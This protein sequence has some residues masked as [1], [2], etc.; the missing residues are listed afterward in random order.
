MQDAP[1]KQPE[2]AERK[3]ET[4]PADPNAA[5]KEQVKEK[6]GDDFEVNEKM[7][8]ETLSDP[9]K[10]K[11]ILDA[12]EQRGDMHIREMKD[13]AFKG[14]GKEKMDEMRTMH[15]AMEKW[16]PSTLVE[17][18]LDAVKEDTDFMK[19]I[20]ETYTG[21]VY[22]NQH[23]V[24]ERAIQRINLVNDDFF[25]K[26]YNNYR[27]DSVGEEAVKKIKDQKNLIAVVDDTN[28]RGISSGGRNDLFEGVPAEA[29][30]GRIEDQNYLAKVA[31]DEGAN[32]AVR[33]QIIRNTKDITVLQTLANR[34]KGIKLDDPL[35]PQNFEEHQ[36]YVAEIAAQRL[37]ELENKE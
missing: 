17:K 3:Q 7:A 8:K 34:A 29:A 31:L 27:F 15:E 37:K 21:G 11:A 33:V 24:A 5:K 2:S 14:G 23:R 20:I 9:K 28:F 35:E 6:F 26:L 13:K 16:H 32:S 22:V 18:M 19:G 10:L 36:E 25:R 30:V 4:A 1:N 12:Y